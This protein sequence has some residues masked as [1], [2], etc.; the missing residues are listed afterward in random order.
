[1]AS[2]PTER[3]LTWRQHE[4]YTSLYQFYLTGLVQLNTLQFAVT[5]GLLAYVLT[6]LSGSPAVRWA[7]VLPAVFAS[8]QCAAIVLGF[9]PLGR[10]VTELQ[11]TARRLGFSHVP[12]LRPLRVFMSVFLVLNLAT[13]AALGGVGFFADRL[14]LSA[15]R[16]AATQPTGESGPPTP[17]APSTP[18]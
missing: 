16:P 14:G 12:S 9:R 7:L 6:N 5:G 4:H 11:D 2:D 18:D 17:R 8:G 13:L 10:L 1:M 3:E 15:A